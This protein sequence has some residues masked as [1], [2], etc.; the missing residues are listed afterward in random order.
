MMEEYIPLTNVKFK[1]RTSSSKNAPNVDEL[2]PFKRRRRTLFDASPQD[3]NELQYSVFPQLKS[4]SNMTELFSDPKKV[5]VLNLP[6]KVSE[7]EILNF[8]NIQM[9]KLLRKEDRNYI[10]GIEMANEKTQ[11]TLEFENEDEATKA[12]KGKLEKKKTK[13]YRFG[14]NQIFG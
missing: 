13:L 8:F 4:T 11:C 6:S 1:A 3:M 7:D 14:W 2:L 5:T 9:K 12:L 10:V